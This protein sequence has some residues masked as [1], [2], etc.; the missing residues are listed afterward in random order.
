ML[1]RKN[2]RTRALK[3][4][5]EPHSG[6]KTIGSKTSAAS[7]AR[8]EARVPVP[9]S[10]TCPA[11][12]VGASSSDTRTARTLEHSA[13]MV[14]SPRSPASRTVRVS[15][16]GTET[17]LARGRHQRS[18]LK[19]LRE[20]R[21]AIDKMHLAAE[22]SM[23]L[24]GGDDA[25]LEEDV[26]LHNELALVPGVA[27][28]DTS[29]AVRKLVVAAK[30]PFDALEGTCLR[31]AAVAL[32][33]CWDDIEVDRKEAAARALF[34]M[35]ATYVSEYITEVEDLNGGLRGFDVIAVKGGVVLTDGT[36]VMASVFLGHL[37]PSKPI[38]DGMISQRG[39][40]LSGAPGD[41][42]GF[43]KLLVWPKEGAKSL[44]AGLP[45]KVCLQTPFIVLFASR[46]MLTRVVL[47]GSAT[48][49]NRREASFDAPW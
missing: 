30:M 16:H 17:F 14:P 46:L 22:N 1:D 4:S 29:V 23:H 32:R 10:G 2:K 37:L 19:K 11:L 6:S 13:Q 44:Y 27:P 28:S 25:T 48:C 31:D 18:A 21:P 38:F 45:V 49:K 36:I 40:N 8:P 24:F 15:F 7:L 33:G 47:S 39:R 26:V 9:S 35:W 43:L 34:T 3:T 5:G 41:H 12:L 20:L 42:V